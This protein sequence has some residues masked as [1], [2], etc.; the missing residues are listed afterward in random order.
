MDYKE[1]RLGLFRV[2]LKMFFLCGII[3]SLLQQSVSAQSCLPEGINFTTQNQIDSFQF[4]Y[5]GC[6]EID[7]DVL[8][9]HF[10]GNY[11]IINLEGLN[12][13]TR[14]GGELL[15]Y[16]CHSLHSLSGLGNLD[17][18]GNN[19]EI[20]D[21]KLLLDL[22]GLN[23][24]QF[25]GGN[26]D[27]RENKK[28]ID[29]S[30]LGDIPIIGGDLIIYENQDLTSLLALGN[31]SF[32]TNDLTILLINQSTIQLSLLSVFSFLLKFLIPKR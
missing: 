19:F 3:V 32:I 22:I 7:G 4:N 31:L 29:F 30:G 15:I 20:K 14:I 25:I 12:V 11:D 6:S 26:F 27:V 17:S 8:I 21:N 5:P 1:Y 13:L 16:R 10:F 23:K 18:I 9:G 2:A 28:L 24:L